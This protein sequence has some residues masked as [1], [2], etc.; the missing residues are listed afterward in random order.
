MLYPSELRA[1]VG[2]ARSS[3]GARSI[4][5]RWNVRRKGSVEIFAFRKY[6]VPLRMEENAELP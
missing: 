6:A 3:R 2:A 4:L 1:R 5:P